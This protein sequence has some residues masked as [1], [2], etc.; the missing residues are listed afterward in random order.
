MNDTQSQSIIH[1]CITNLGP[2]R[3]PQPTYGREGICG[4]VYYGDEADRWYAVD[5]DACRTLAAMAGED[6]YQRWCE[7][8]EVIGEGATMR[9]ALNVA[10]AFTMQPWSLA[11]PT[12]P[13]EPEVDEMA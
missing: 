4:L 13:R 3:H 12:I 6:I 11:P 1:S 2:D 8:T 10:A 9:A 5:L 7:E